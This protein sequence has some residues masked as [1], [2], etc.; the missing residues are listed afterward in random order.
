MKLFAIIFLILILRFIYNKQIE[1]YKN[2]SDL[3]MNLD[4]YSKND[5]NKLSSFIYPNRDLDSILLKFNETMNTELKYDQLPVIKTYTYTPIN[6]EQKI[7]DSNTCLIKK[8][9]NSINNSNLTKYTL[10]NIEN[11]YKS[12]L[13]DNNYV[14]TV[15]FFIHEKNKF[16]T[17][18]MVLEYSQSKNNIVLHFIRTLQS[19]KSINR[20][21]NI[22]Y[23]NNLNNWNLNSQLD[24]IK[25]LFV[26]KNRNFQLLGKG[27]YYNK[28]KHVHRQLPGLPYVNP[29]LFTDKYKKMYY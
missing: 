28:D 1:N 19:I 5:V 9:L 18:K 14:I 7:K 8:I 20:N 11:I 26:T 10:M 21:T 13:L 23:V 17:R 27:D 16:S 6:L 24:L 3:T 12:V 29:S 4:N 15:V 2:F 22:K 25:T